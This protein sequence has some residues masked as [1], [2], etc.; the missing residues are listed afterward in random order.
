MGGLVAGAAQ[1]YAQDSG[2]TTNTTIKQIGEDHVANITINGTSRSTVTQ[3]GTGNSVNINVSGF[4]NGRGEGK[5][6]QTGDNNDVTLGIDG[7]ENN[8]LVEQTGDGATNRAALT[9]NGH[10]NDLTIFQNASGLTSGLANI[11]EVSQIGNGNIAFVDQTAI[12]AAD[13]FFDNEV[14]ITQNGNGNDASVVQNGHGNTSEQLQ[15]GDDNSS[16]VIQN[17]DNNELIH[18]QYGDGLSVPSEFGGIVIEQSGGS[19]IMIE[20]YSPGNGPL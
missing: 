10:F 4:D 11:A 5:V 19:S 17:G 16:N 20:Q 8:Y 1:A 7:D 13:A 2:A 12:L 3:S 9:Q 14:L 15:D 18:R 6:E